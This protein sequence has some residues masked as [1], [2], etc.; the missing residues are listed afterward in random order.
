MRT[1]N[2][3]VFPPH[4]LGRI[5]AAPFQCLVSSARSACGRTSGTATLLHDANLGGHG[6][7]EKE[8]VCVLVKEKRPD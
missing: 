3:D 7:D 6:P 1:I 2:M 8:S 5:F 4:V